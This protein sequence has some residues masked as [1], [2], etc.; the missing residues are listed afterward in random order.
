M[1]YWGIF[2]AV[3]CLGC[4]INNAYHGHWWWV[5]ALAGSII[6]DVWVAYLGWAAMKAYGN[7][8]P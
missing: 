5:L 2:W 6:I 8:N 4:L 3:W 1:F 7:P